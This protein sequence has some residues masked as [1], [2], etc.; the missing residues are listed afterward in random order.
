MG[1]V[2]GAGSDAGRFAEMRKLLDWGFAH[3]RTR[4]LVS[5][6]APIGVVKVGRSGDAT[7]SVRAAESYSLL[8]SIGPDPA[9]VRVILPPAVSTSVWRGQQLGTAEVYRS[10]SVVATVPLLAEAAVSDPGAVRA[11]PVPKPPAAKPAESAWERLTRSATHTMGLLS[12]R[13]LSSP[14]DAR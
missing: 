4:V 7:V 11:V 9:T 14:V 2:L 8:E 12:L 1:V 3:Y 6:E 10:G 5:D 13:L